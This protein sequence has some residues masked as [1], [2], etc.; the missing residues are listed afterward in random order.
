MKEIIPLG[1]NRYI[2]LDLG[3]KY[4]SPFTKLLVPAF[5]IAIAA[6]TASAIMG[7]DITNTNSVPTQQQTK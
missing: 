1:N 5:V 2:H 6:I 4:R 7:V 3:E